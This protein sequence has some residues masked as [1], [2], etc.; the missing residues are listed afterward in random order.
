MQ[1]T[2]TEIKFPLLSTE[3]DYRIFVFDT[4]TKGFQGIPL[5]HPLNEL[6]QISVLDLHTHEKFRRYCKPDNP[7]IVPENYNIHKISPAI[8]ESS[9]IPTAQ[10]LSEL[11]QFLRK[12]GMEKQI[13]LVAHNCSFDA[14][15]LMKEYLLKCGKFHGFHRHSK[16]DFLFLDS[17]GAMRTLFPELADQYW[18]KE[19]P[20]SM[21]TLM[22][23]FYP[24]VDI[25]NT[26]NADFD[27][28][29]LSCL[30]V[31]KIYPRLGSD[32]KTWP[33]FLNFS[34]IPAAPSNTLVTEVPGFGQYRTK[35]LLQAVDRYFREDAGLPGIPISLFRCRHLL[36]YG[37]RRYLEYRSGLPAKSN[38]G[39][40]EHWKFICREVELLCRTT[41][42]LMLHSDSVITELLS[43]VANLTTFDFSFFTAPEPDPRH[44]PGMPPVV[45]FP[46]LAGEP[47]S[48]L[49]L[50]VKPHEARNLYEQLN[51]KT[52][53]EV[54]VDFKF[55]DDFERMNWIKRLNTCLE[56][57][58]TIK[59]LGEIFATAR[60]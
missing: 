4:E 3:L 28:Q 42:K 31:N 36:E 2:D 43:R 39:Q 51:L 48:Y 6:I 55:C 52:F 37:H 22:E 18:P 60:F 32:W 17:L 59:R 7:I 58:L 56:R 30:F 19:K 27:V 1:Y 50:V 15:I 44:P 40:M 13:V 41:P 23:H 21:E 35:L 54:F 29:I 8:L 34:S 12:D 25:N 46:T 14:F 57:P 9:G 53:N 24:R 33:F 26:H 11:D 10:V 49:P 47:E 5:Y 16:L 20:Y 45:F 38:T